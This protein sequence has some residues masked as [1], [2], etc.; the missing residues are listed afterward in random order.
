M[1]TN[2]IM[3][4]TKTITWYIMVPL[5]REDKSTNK[6]LEDLGRRYGHGMRINVKK[7]KQIMTATQGTT[8]DGSM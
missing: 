5:W 1:K 6:I 7:R 2:K 3:N 8:A 4:L